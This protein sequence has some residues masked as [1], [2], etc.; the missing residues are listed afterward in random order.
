V[1][2]KSVTFAFLVEAAD[3]SQAFAR[4]KSVMVAYD[5]ARETSRPIPPEW[6]KKLTDFEGNNEK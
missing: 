1:G 2:I 4:G 3:G 5:N 6:R